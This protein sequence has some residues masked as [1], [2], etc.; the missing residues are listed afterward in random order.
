MKLRPS[1]LPEFSWVKKD[2]DIRRPQP[3]PSSP[4]PDAL[5]KMFSIDDITTPVDSPIFSA[6]PASYLD[7]SLKIL[8]AHR[9]K[10]TFQ[11]ID[12]AGKLYTPHLPFDF[13]YYRAALDII[14]GILRVGEDNRHAQEI[15]LQ[16]DGN[17]SEES[18]SLPSH[19][20][21]LYVP[22]FSS[23]GERM[24]IWQPIESLQ[25][26]YG[27]PR[28]K[29]NRVVEEYLIRMLTE[30]PRLDGND[31]TA[32]SGVR[33]GNHVW[34]WNPKTNQR[35]HHSG[36][37]WADK[38]WKYAFDPDYSED[39][40]IPEPILHEAKHY[41]G[42][43]TSDDPNWLS[44]EDNPD[45]SNLLRTFRGNLLMGTEQKNGSLW[46]GN[47]GNGKS[48]LINGLIDAFGE[49]AVRSIDTEA[50]KSKGFDRANA[51]A[52][53]KHALYAVND[54]ANAKL[55]L[56]DSV[57][58][59]LTTGG[60]LHARTIGQDGEDFTS[61]AYVILASN[62]IPDDQLDN[63]VARRWCFV[64]FKRGTGDDFHPLVHFLERYGI[65]PFLWLSLM[66]A[67][68]DPSSDLT[69]NTL[70]EWNLLTGE[71]KRIVTAIMTSE[72]RVYIKPEGTHLSRGVAKKLGLVRVGSRSA[73][74]HAYKPDI[75]SSTFDRYEKI[76]RFQTA[77]Q[78][79]QEED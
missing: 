58:K 8:D 18:Y 76:W 62:H 6:F 10:R 26:Q 74:G 49:T 3:R 35:E 54:D 79:E 53:L 68:E 16:S 48:L 29:V 27:I 22:C 39:G 69:P 73:S 65:I 15:A 5:I 33:I 56:A 64:N 25:A 47:S 78:E 31:L 9:V 77:Q 45:Y 38:A 4:Y 23:R 43:L 30:Q 14:Q 28:A 61:R 41:L 11:K 46:V 17:E 63:A 70:S 32:H 66:Q 19:Q 52:S 57:L 71:E 42:W 20:P 50:L 36:K 37:E 51:V 75:N 12:G 24:N 7:D 34:F 55:E 40:K 72:N 60:R 13:G 67:V 59:T 1:P 21:T 2:L 44:Y